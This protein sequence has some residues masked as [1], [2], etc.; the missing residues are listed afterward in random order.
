[1]TKPDNSSFAPID[2]SSRHEP[3][4]C[5]VC[6]SV[7]ALPLYS[8]TFRGSMS[9]APRYFLSHRKAT[10]RGPIVKC[11]NCGFVFTS[12]RFL[13]S[14]YDAIYSSIPK[15]H[16]GLVE[17]DAAKSARFE[18]LAA[19]VR[20]HS[21]RGAFIDFGCGDGAFLK[22]M[23]DPAGKGFEIGP[24]G[25]RTAGRSEI[26]TDD[27]AAFAQSRDAPAHAFEF[28]T[29]FDV[30]EHLPRIEKDVAI[31]RSLLKPGGLFFATV[32]NIES[33]MARFMGKRWNMLLL[34]HLWYF[35]PRT[36]TTFLSKHGFAEVRQR[37]LPYDAPLAHIINRV[38]QN[39][40]MRISTIP[41][42]ITKLV[43]PVPAGILLGIYRAV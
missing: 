20:K 7:E 10:A 22:K 3:D 41:K 40:G 42:G 35:S 36:F 8:P 12:P 15:P 30:L 24:P 17:F 16:E 1:V 37:P 2:W 38:A 21:N 39:F 31:I 4:P 19:I 34:E 43:L 9:D 27:W 32:P 26:I 23:D 25:R 33:L 18:R 5:I 14:E 28:I 13:P 29:A 11:G 6:A